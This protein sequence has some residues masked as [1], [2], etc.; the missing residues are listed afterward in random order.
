MVRFLEQIRG[1]GFAGVVRGE[2]DRSQRDLRSR[3]CYIPVPLKVG[4][5]RNA[6]NSLL[7]RA[8]IRLRKAGLAQDDE[9]RNQSSN[10]FPSSDES[11]PNSRSE[12]FWSVVAIVTILVILVLLTR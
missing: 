9:L 7:C 4:L 3:C 8:L 6:S 11:V 12:L 1:G 5:N 10:L 2:R